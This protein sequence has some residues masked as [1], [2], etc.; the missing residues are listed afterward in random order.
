MLRE[1]GHDA[2]NGNNTYCDS[3]ERA[4]GSA[5]AVEDEGEGKLEI[6]LYGEVCNGLVTV[7][8]M[9]LDRINQKGVEMHG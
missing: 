2:D 5:W 7:L 6:M 9:E 8:S 3:Q 1:P 4:H